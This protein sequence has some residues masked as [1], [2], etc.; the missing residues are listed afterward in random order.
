MCT[1]LIYTHLVAQHAL[2][3]VVGQPGVEG[4][5]HVVAVRQ[6]DPEA[7]V[8]HLAVHLKKLWTLEKI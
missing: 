1:C 4:R 7:V 8:V 2:L 3:P 6:V 5:V